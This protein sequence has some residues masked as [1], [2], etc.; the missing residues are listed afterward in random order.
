MSL[1]WGP[2]SARENASDVHADRAAGSARHSRQAAESL[3]AEVLDSV[4]RAPAATLRWVE[5]WLQ[6]G[7]SRFHALVHRP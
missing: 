3:C 7:K 2:P 6:R 4:E 1:V 5:S